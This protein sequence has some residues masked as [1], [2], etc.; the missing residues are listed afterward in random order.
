MA[1][2]LLLVG[3]SSMWSVIP[4]LGEHAGGGTL[5]DWLKRPMLFSTRSPD[6]VCEMLKKGFL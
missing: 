4:G 3:V 5:T 6:I 2:G 1:L